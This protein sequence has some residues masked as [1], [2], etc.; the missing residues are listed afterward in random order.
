MDPARVDDVHVDA[1]W[2]ELLLLI[3]GVNE[4]HKATSNNAKSGYEVAN[5]VSES[6]Y[7]ARRSSSF[8]L[9]SS[10]HRFSL[11]KM[12]ICPAASSK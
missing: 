9:C 6:T 1:L 2:P 4:G 8:V 5:V 12:L 3:H 7:S 10:V 11:R